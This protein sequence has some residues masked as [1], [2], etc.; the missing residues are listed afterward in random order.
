M[1]DDHDRGELADV[2]PDPALRFCAFLLAR[3]GTERG[4]D[5]PYLSRRCTLRVDPS[6]WFGA[7]VDVPCDCDDRSGL[8]PELI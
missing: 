2:L 6:G 4:H 1:G 5:R 8:D 3:S 7:I